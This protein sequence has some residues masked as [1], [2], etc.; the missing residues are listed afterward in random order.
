[1]VLTVEDRDGV[2]VIAADGRMDTNTS[3]GFGERVVEQVRAGAR[4]VVI[5]LAKIAYISS[6]GFRALLVAAKSLDEVDGRLALAGV[7]GEVRRL[8]DIAAVSDLFVVCATR[9]EALEKV[10]GSA[11]R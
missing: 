11:L 4:R 3:M 1:M 2:C 9:D 6:A 7:T 5:D 10:G 8:F